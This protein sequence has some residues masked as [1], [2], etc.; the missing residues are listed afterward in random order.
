MPQSREAR[1]VPVLMR[2]NEMPRLAGPGTF[3]LLNE[4][5]RRGESQRRRRTKWVLRWAT[6]ALENNAGAIATIRGRMAVPVD[7]VL[8]SP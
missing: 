2:H 4:F 8:N 1:G 5:R 3:D 7:R 6:G